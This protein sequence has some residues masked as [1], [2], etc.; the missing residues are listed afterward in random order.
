MPRTC[1]AAYGLPNLDRGRRSAT[2]VKWSCPLAP[3]APIPGRACPCNKLGCFAGCLQMGSGAALGLCVCRGAC[4]SMHACNEASMRRHVG[5]HLC[6]L[7]TQQPCQC[8]SLA[9]LRLRAMFGT[10]VQHSRVGGPV[11]SWGFPAP[12]IPTAIGV[13]GLD[14]DP[15]CAH[16]PPKASHLGGPGA[17]AGEDQTIA[18]QAGKQRDSRTLGPLGPPFASSVLTTWQRAIIRPDVHLAQFAAPTAAMCVQH[19]PSAAVACLAS[20]GRGRLKPKAV[21]AGLH[22]QAFDL[23]RC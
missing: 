15:E 6:L 8:H 12:P 2:A 16:C 23:R 22:R 20:S 7:P 14:A 17:T 21:L 18:L 19:A 13:D 1:A 9:A 5:A 3:A 4:L 11:P 10:R